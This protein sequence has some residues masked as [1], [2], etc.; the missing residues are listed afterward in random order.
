MKIPSLAL[1]GLLAG[2]ASAAVAATSDDIVARGEYLTTASDCMACH[3]G[4]GQ[5]PF[6]GGLALETPFGQLVTPNITPDKETGIGNWT[7]DDFYR[8]LHEGL[9]KDGENIYPAMPFTHYTKM[10][11]ED[12]LAIKAYL[13]SL[14]PVHA[15]HEVNKL[16][17]PYNIRSSLNVWRVLYFKAGEF[18]PDPNRSA[19]LNRGAYLVEGLAHCGMCHSGRNALG[20]EQP[21]DSLGGAPINGWYAPNISADAQAGIGDWSQD[22]LF[23]YLKTGSAPGKGVAAGPMSEVVHTSLSRLKDEDIRAMAAY[24]KSAPARPEEQQVAVATGGQASPG[25]GPYLNHCAS[26]HGVDGK[27]IQGA[28]PALD[29]NG[30]VTSAGPENV[31]RV[32][33]GGLKAAGSYGKMP[34]IGGGVGD[35]EIADIT[36]YVRT[37]WSNKGAANAGAGDVGALRAQTP[38]VLSSEDAKCGDTTNA[39]GK[40]ASTPPSDGVAP[41]L[42]GIDDVNMYDRIGQILDQQADAKDPARRAGIVNGLSDAYCEVVAKDVSLSLEQR[43]AR[44]NRFGQMIYSQLAGPDTAMK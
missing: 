44:Y 31:I 22:D 25:A 12:A 8:I 6:S 39:G 20:A 33:L 21:S 24:L 30:S 23:A 41:L 42:Q 5:K 13:F 27:G 28:V 40:W 18:V 37:A 26:C 11:R 36:N 19:E 35:Q 4:P 29:G 14:E 38:I 2:T 3:S 17:F 34:A 7:D 10:T 16:E 1:M 9:G 43:R 15:E 32:I